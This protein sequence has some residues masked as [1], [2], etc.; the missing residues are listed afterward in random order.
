[1]LSTVRGSASRVQGWTEQVDKY[2]FF[3][4]RQLFDIIDGGAVEYEKSG[5][6]DGIVV[7][8]AGAT[9]KA[10]EIY[11]ENFKSSVRAAAMI[12]IKRKNASSPKQVPGIKGANAFC[13]EVIGGC[14][15]YYVKGG[16]YFEITL[17]GYDV[18]AS[19]A[20]DAMLFVDAF[21]KDLRK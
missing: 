9:G 21:A 15:A 16:L 14:V 3:N 13:D 12:G 19:A 17:T 5:L 10:A 6:V 1:M 11:I 4:V 7:S 20:T 8:L 18:A 2:R